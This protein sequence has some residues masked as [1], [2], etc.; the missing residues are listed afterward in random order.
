M[1]EPVPEYGNNLQSRKARKELSVFPNPSS[2]NARK[3]AAL[4]AFLLMP[5]LADAAASPYDAQ[6]FHSAQDAGR[7]ILV[8][9]HASWCPEC[10]AQDQVMNRLEREPRYAKVQR[11]RI[12][13]DSQKDLVK[14]F[15]AK[16]QSTLVLYKGR[17]EVARLVGETREAKI[18]SMLDQAL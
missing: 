8:E 12:D 9:I 15:K 16:M 2:R 1:L 7:P 5:A 6:A 3:V 11:F 13:F 14:A 10:K 17:H 4:F 18:R